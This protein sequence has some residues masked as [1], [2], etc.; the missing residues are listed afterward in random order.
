[1]IVSQATLFTL[2]HPA[3]LTNVPV[4]DLQWQGGLIPASTTGN[5]TVVGATRTFNF[6]SPRGPSFGYYQIS[7]VVRTTR[8]Q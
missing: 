4:L 5:G 3:R 7:E 2:T 8:F 6:T 1:M